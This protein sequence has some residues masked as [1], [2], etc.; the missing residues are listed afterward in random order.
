MKLLFIMILFSVLPSNTYASDEPMELEKIDVPGF[1]DEELI[2]IEREL[3]EVKIHN[4]NGTKKINKFGKT[5][6]LLSE[7]IP[8]QIELA[9][10][11]KR[12]NQILNARE[13]YVECIS[14]KD[15]DDCTDL[16]EELDKLNIRSSSN[17]S[18]EQKTYLTNTSAMAQ[19]RKCSSVTQE[20][21]PDFQAVVQ[22]DIS[23]DNRGMVQSV[24]IDHDES[25]IS[26]DL[27]MF[28]KCVVHF[29]RK[30]Q[31]HNPTGNIARVNQTMLFGQI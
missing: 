14:S 15:D 2:R 30:L 9:K 12:F 11:R 28:S 20:Y 13:K 3:E 5:Q 22:L 27:P 7:L 25:E 24:Y 17:E 19:I 26:H 8:K 29:A 1:V 18:K 31:F 10:G 23:V 16:K 4:K 21:F 6:E